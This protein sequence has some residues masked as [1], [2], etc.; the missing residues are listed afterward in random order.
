MVA[1][2]ISVSINQLNAKKPAHKQV[3]GFYRF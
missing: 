1:A 2:L 3:P